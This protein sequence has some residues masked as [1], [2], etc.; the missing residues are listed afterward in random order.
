[1]AC[2][3]RA[4]DVPDAAAEKAIA[5]ALAKSGAPSISV[6]VVGHGGVVYARAF[7]MASLS[8]ARPA[9]ASTR[10]FVGSISKQFTAA[11]ILLAAED[12]SLSL[13]D[14]VSRYYP[15]LTRASEVSVRQLLSHTS[16]YEDFA[17]QDYLVPEWARP[18]T[19]D[20]VIRAWAGKPLDFEPGTRWQYSNTGYVLA[21]RIL[22]KA[23][24]EK[25]LAFLRRRIFGP[26]GMAS[27]GDGYAERRPG[28][29][30]PYTRY[31]LG[32]PRPV[33]H[34]GDGWYYGA[35]ELAMTPTDLARWDA[36]FLGHRL[37]GGKAYRDFTSEVH[38]A[39]GDSTGYALGLAVGRFDRIAWISHN[40]EVS[41][42]LTQNCVFPDRGVAVA[43]CSNEDGVFIV[44][45]VADLLARSVMEPGRQDPGDA[46]KQELARVG[47][48]VE[49][50]RQGRIDRALL[51]A[52]A[53]AYF[54]AQA[55]ADFRASLSG[56][57]PVVSARRTEVALRG[58]MTFGRYEVTLASGAVTVT[59]YLTASGLLEQFMVSADD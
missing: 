4:S 19:P 26:L 55:L 40:G 16:G 59:T 42:F 36:A 47:A 10:Y 39:N 53:S 37:L 23:T 44:S 17:P 33:A 45:A 54:S 6:A 9:D 20:A 21:A 51:T 2:G 13:D 35:A 5:A 57:G 34:E 30:E 43:V 49:G 32:P 50:L 27:A 3:A 46:P 15:G 58:G 7:G 25:L 8:P 18:T 31:G 22:E 38:L 24:G 28:D 11:A 1:M 52:N 29:A 14:R 48:L 12:G 56:L 41:G